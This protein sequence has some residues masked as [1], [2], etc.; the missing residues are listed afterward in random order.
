MVVRKTNRGTGSYAY[1]RGAKHPGL[2]SAG[3]VRTPGKTK[4][5]AG[6]RGKTI[7]TD[8]PTP[9]P[10]GRA[11]GTPLVKPDRKAG[12]P[13]QY[14]AKPPA[15]PPARGP[16]GGKPKVLLNKGSKNPYRNPEHKGGKNPRRADPLGRKNPRRAAKPPKLGP[17]GGKPKVILNP[18]S[19]N[20]YRPPA[21]KG[22]ANP[23]RG[24]GRVANPN[25]RRKTKA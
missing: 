23:R 16:K 6:A 1:K 21:S 20:P 7:V 22:G 2:M 24:G 14:S 4:K 25:P 3:A 17:K 18:G 8:V 11:R 13:A 9:G 15:E 19:K 5:T 12:P 10:R